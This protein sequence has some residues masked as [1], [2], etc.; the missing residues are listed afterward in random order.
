MMQTAFI[1]MRHLGL[2]RP[3]AITPTTQ[4]R[5][6]NVVIQAKATAYQPPSST[7]GATELDALE[8]Y[9]EVSM[10]YIPSLI[11]SSLHLGRDCGSLVL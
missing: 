9:S 7:T 11:N 8:R 10:H 2:N 6:R 4:N 3:T 5:R 1:T